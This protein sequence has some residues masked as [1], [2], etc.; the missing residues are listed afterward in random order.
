MLF[1]TMKELEGNNLKGE[2]VEGKIF[3]LF[4]Y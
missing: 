3:S 4:I 1:N 2:A